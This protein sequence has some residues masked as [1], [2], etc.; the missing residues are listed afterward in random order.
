M[1]TSSKCAFFCHLEDVYVRGNLNPIKR[2]LCVKG[3]PD[4][5]G[6]GIASH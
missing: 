1:H 3:A 5:V 6:W 2:P 4:L